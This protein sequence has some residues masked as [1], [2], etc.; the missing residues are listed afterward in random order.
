VLNIILDHDSRA[1]GYARICAQ[2]VADCEGVQV[3]L[4]RQGY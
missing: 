1:E 3:I 2:G 4:D